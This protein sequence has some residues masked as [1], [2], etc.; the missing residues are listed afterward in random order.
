M[1]LPA[2]STSNVRPV[3]GLVAELRGLAVQGLTRMYRP[4][5][6]LFAFRV[7]RQGE[8]L[9]LEGSSRR[10]TAI[11][12]I[13]LA[14]ESEAVQASV[15]AG[16][17]VRAACARLVGELDAIENLGDVALVLWAACAAGYPERRSVAERLLALRPG[18][19]A[20]PTVEVAWTLA[21]L[22]ADAD[23]PVGP[24]RHR[25]ARRLIASFDPHSSMFPHH[26]GGR[27][28][29]FRGH[30][31]CFA[32]LVY[33][34]HALA[35]YAELF[36]DAETRDIALRCAGALCARQ[37]PAGQWWW[38][39]DRRTGEI[40]E[41]YPVYA[42]HQDAMAPMAL[43]ALERASGVDLRP[44]IAKGLAWLTHAPE[45]GGGSLIDADAGL[46]WRKV[47]RR[48]PRK[49][50]RYAQAAASRLHPAFR[51]PGLDTLFPP[52]AVDYED[53]PYHLG[54]LLHAWPAER[55]TP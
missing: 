18:D 3:V 43:L 41:R 49:L 9:V 4:E 28:G 17:G 55:A 8:A 37:G 39:Y 36:G 20:H 52:G 45:L 7:R 10:Y 53:R 19:A 26:L 1:S 32:D 30:V 2:P 24:L 29:G 50:S 54:W 31:S 40:V 44:P 11:A 12:L 47:A 16:T 21:A 33:P 38:H 13:G 48:E 46:I 51:T 6:G 5:H 25:L 15:L 27:A 14:G 34:I 42:I 35:R 23:A 22:C